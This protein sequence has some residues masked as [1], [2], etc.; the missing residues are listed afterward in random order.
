MVSA[1]KRRK[2]KKSAEGG[3]GSKVV[4][5]GYVCGKRGGSRDQGPLGSGSKVV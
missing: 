4:R 1:R 3:L 5:V 2:E